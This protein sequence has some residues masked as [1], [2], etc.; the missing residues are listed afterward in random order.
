M[1]TGGTTEYIFSKRW[2]RVSVSAHSAGAYT[3]TLLVMLNVKRGG[4][5]AP[6]PSPAR[7]NFTLITEYTP[8]SS[9]CNSVYSMGGTVRLLRW[10]GLAD[11]KTRLKLPP[12][13]PYLKNGSLT[14]PT[15]VFKSLWV[16]GGGGGCRNVVDLNNK[17]NFGIKHKSLIFLSM[18]LGRRLIV[19]RVASVG[20]VEPMSVFYTK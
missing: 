19:G 16:G 6:P 14:C 4:G 3:A 20:R 18:I 5:R 12:L 8:E 10:A 13:S 7:A 9:G 17:V 11:Y 1:L 2:N 15:L